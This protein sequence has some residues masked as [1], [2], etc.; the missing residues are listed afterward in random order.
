ME[1]AVGAVLALAIGLF[2]TVVGLDRDRAFY[3]TVLLVIALLYGLFAVLGGSL[4]SLRWE[5]IGIAAFVL[6]AV[7]GF[8]INLWWVAGALAGHGVYDWFHPRLISNPGVPS[9]WPMFCMTYDIVA[10][11]YLAW[12]LGRS[13]LSATAGARSQR[14]LDF[15]HG[16]APHVQRELLAAAQ[17]HLNG[18]AA[19]GFRHLERA[20]VLGQA[21][22]REHVRVHWHMLLWALRHRQ[23]AEMAAQ[24]FRILGA[25]LM[26][27]IGL[28]PT[29][30]TGGGNISAFRRLPLP[31]DL[32]AII[33]SVRRTGSA[34]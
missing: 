12:L 27:G 31:P 16:I 29:G 22:T 9:W 24:I 34:P 19:A 21:S 4:E 28:V 23:P 33:A 32:A 15:H 11:A 17:S 5:S 8:R 2:G 10:A 7:V 3:P 13:R 1:Y 18:D 26:T 14:P 25:A 6:L 20:H 30:N